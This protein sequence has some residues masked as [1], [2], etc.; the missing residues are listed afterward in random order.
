MRGGDYFHPFVGNVGGGNLVCLF[1]GKVLP[2]GL[3]IPAIIG[4]GRGEKI[5]S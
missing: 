2:T 1:V 3:N 4:P 5:T